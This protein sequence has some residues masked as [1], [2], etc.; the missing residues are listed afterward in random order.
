MPRLN[1]YGFSIWSSIDWTKA[2]QEKLVKDIKEGLDWRRKEVETNDSQGILD[3]AH[4]MHS[5]F[6]VLQGRH[7]VNPMEYHRLFYPIFLN[8][9]KQRDKT[10]NLVK[11]LESLTSSLIQI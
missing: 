10:V 3:Q 5:L 7:G 8:H 2:N 4:A 9:L 11:V 1:L 6:S